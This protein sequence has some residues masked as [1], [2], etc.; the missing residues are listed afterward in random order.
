MITQQIHREK[1]INY[2]KSTKYEGKNLKNNYKFK[3]RTLT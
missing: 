2:V 3:G 1:E